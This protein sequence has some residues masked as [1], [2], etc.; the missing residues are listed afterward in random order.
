M[1]LWT[2][3]PV[4]ISSI[5]LFEQRMAVTKRV[6]RPRAGAGLG[7]AFAELPGGAVAGQRVFAEL[8][9]FAIV[10]ALEIVPVLVVG[11]GM[12]SAVPEILVQILRRLRNAAIAGSNAVLGLA[13][14]FFR[15]GRGGAFARLDA[16]VH[17]ES[18]ANLGHT[19]IMGRRALKTRKGIS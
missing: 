15:L 1:T 12:G 6:L 18:G 7:G 5:V 11:A 4:G 8:L 10:H 17:F 19:A 16:H 9:D 2:A 14:A 13:K 3:R